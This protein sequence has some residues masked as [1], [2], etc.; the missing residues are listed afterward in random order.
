VIEVVLHQVLSH[1]SHISKHSVCSCSTVVVSLI[2]ILPYLG[3]CSSLC[4]Q[5]A[6][7]LSLCICASATS[8]GGRVAMKAA[9][10]VSNTSARSSGERETKKEVLSISWE[11]VGSA[12]IDPPTW[13]RLA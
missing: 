12:G 5:W 11:F 13:S 8:S 10:A 7:A 1:V 3:C 9:S 4:C 2:L 6:A